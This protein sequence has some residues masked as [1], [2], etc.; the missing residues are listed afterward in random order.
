MVDDQARQ[1]A[2]RF[3]QKPDGPFLAPADA[4]RIP[5]VVNLPRLLAACE[6]VADDTDTA[7]DLR[8]LLAAGLLAGRGAAESRNRSRALI[9]LQQPPGQRRSMRISGST[10]GSAAACCLRKQGIFRVGIRRSRCCG[11]RTR[12]FRLRSAKAKNFAKTRKNWD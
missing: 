10:I 6:R 1:G 11:L 3:A 8:L 5:P 12:K 7:E 2:M 4:E 9:L